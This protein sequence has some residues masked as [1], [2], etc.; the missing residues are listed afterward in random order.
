MCGSYVFVFKISSFS[1]P[2]CCINVIDITF[3]AAC[4]RHLKH[5]SVLLMSNYKMNK[6][7][8]QHIGFIAVFHNFNQLAI[9]DSSVHSK[10]LTGYVSSCFIIHFA[11][12]SSQSRFKTPGPFQEFILGGNTLSRSLMQLSCM[13]SSETTGTVGFRYATL[14]G[15][16]TKL[17]LT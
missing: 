5:N 12:I 10:I 2:G 11:I 17:Q 7:A 8:C 6:L 1:L 15:Q 16:L 9:S 14:F 3:T 13:R 4:I